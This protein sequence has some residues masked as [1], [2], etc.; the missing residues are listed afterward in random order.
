MS[1]AIKTA[2]NHKRKTKK[3]AK[4]RTNKKRWVTRTAER[5][6]STGK[7]KSKL[8]RDM[9]VM[10]AN[11]VAFFSIG[12]LIQFLMAESF[13]KQANSLLLAFAIART[14]AITGITLPEEEEEVALGK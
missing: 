1:S 11:F 9:E 3:T 5:T 8:E 7:A 10:G 4:K 12:V 6:L 13:K 2:G 14:L